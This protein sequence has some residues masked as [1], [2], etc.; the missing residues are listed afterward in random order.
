MEEIKMLKSLEL[1]KEVKKGNFSVLKEEGTNWLKY[2]AFTK[3]RHVN[4]E[5]IKSISDIK[6]NVTLEYVEDRKSVV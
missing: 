5:N 6:M 4:I 3:E 1:I 2:L